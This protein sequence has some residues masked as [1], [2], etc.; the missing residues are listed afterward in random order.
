[1]IFL[2]KIKAAVIGIGNMGKNHVR[3]YHELEETELV[4]ISDLNED[5]LIK[6]KKK[7]GC[8]TYTDYKKML[9]EEEIDII[10]IV[11]PTKTHKDVTLEVIEKNINFLLEKP[12]SNNLE[13]GQLIIEEANKKD[14]KFLIGHIERYNPAIQKIK[15][16]IDDKVLG[17]ITTISAKRVGLFPPQIKDSNIIIDVSIHDIEIINYLLND[18][19]DEV[20]VNGGKAL[21]QEREDF[22][23][24]LMCYGP[25]T[26]TIQSNWITPIKIRKLNI[27][28]TKGYAEIDYIT[29]ELIL[30]E[31]DYQK[32]D[33]NFV[34]FVN[35]GQPKKIE[36]MIKSEEP[37]KLEIKNLID[38]IKE[39]KTPLITGQQALDALEIS[40]EINKKI[41]ERN[42]F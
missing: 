37:L 23:E 4:A 29:Q 9:N 35:T 20:F 14:V 1:M 6:S 5:L 12:I 3:I 15:E 32:K 34:E 27:T 39:D 36:I 19:P 16:M 40:L 31:N 42:S 2:K 18:K 13:D 17:E 7:Y 33:D 21:N 30:Y 8:N 11:T 41:K 38:S 10:S 22:V 25:I 26:G 28:G 24:I